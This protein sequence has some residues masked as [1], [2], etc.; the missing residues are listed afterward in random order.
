MT[1]KDYYK[2]LGISKTATESEIKSAFRNKAREF[3]PDKNKGNKVAEEK[4]KEVSEAYEV[5]KDKDKRSKYD[6]LGSSYNRF[7]QDGG[8]DNDFDWSNWAN[9]QRSSRKGKTVG[10]F[11]NTGGNMSDFFEK[12][13]G[14]TYKSNPFTGTHKEPE[15][16][17]DHKTEITISL[18]ETYKGVKRRLKVNNE[19]I[20][21]N[22]KPGVEDNQTL[23]LSEK[24]HVSFD[25]GRNG[26]LI[27]TIKVEED[28]VYKRNLDNLEVSVDVPLYTA[29]LGGEISINTLSGQIKLNIPPESQQGKKLKLKGLGMPIYKSPKKYGDLYA[30]LN[31]KLPTKLSDEEKDLFKKLSA[32]RN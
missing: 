27:I 31:I 5:L 11:F 15:K 1:Y 13:F 3:H 2:I 20:E 6:N 14:S 7:R 25:G 32:F 16:G 17:K 24:G 23:K 22:I 10:D 30:I 28:K 12:I 19:S 26:D 21:I 9:Q 29:V 8:R 4:F 18:A